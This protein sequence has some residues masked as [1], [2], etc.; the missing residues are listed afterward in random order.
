MKTNLKTRAHAHV[1]KQLHYKLQYKRMRILRV[2]LLCCYAIDSRYLLIC[3][4][5][6]TIIL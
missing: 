4:N 5:T 3:P 6:T 1:R 2:E